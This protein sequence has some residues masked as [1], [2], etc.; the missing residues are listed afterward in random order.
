MLFFFG[1]F[2][3]VLLV[4]FLVC[5][6]RVLMCSFS[7]VWFPLRFTWSWP[8]DIC[9][10]VSCLHLQLLSFTPPV[11]SNSLVVMRWRLNHIF[12]I[13]IKLLFLVFFYLSLSLPFIF[14]CSWLIA[15]DELSLL[16]ERIFVLFQGVV[17]YDIGWS[18][19]FLFISCLW[20]L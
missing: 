6:E 9:S 5:F 17:D 13:I 3:V 10:Y 8:F 1:L 2:Y 16:L 14:P 20:V 15:R 19:L 11:S 7:F 18:N 4:D 12:F